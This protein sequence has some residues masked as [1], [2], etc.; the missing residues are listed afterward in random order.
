[1]RHV[2]LALMMIAAVGCGSISGGGADGGSPGNTPNKCHGSPP[3]APL[4]DA[5]GGAACSA[6]AP[7]AAPEVCIMLPGTDAGSCGPACQS[8]CDCPAWLSCQNGVCGTCSDSSCGAGERCSLVTLPHGA[9][10]SSNNDCGLGGYC[11]D[12]YCDELRVCTQC[13]GGCQTCNSNAQCSPGEVCDNGACATCSSDS[14][15]GPS[16]KCAATHTSVQC[17]CSQTS[18]C[19]SGETCQSGICAPLPVMGCNDPD[20]MNRCQTGQACING[21]CGACSSFEDCN[22]NPD[23]LLGSLQGLACI[24]GACAACTANSQ[25]GGGQAC[26]G[27]TCGTCVVDAQCGASGKCSDGYCVCSTD[28]QCDSGQRCGAGVCVE[29]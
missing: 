5:D 1:M 23:G 3:L 8:D 16:A 19:A 24:N 6:T 7:C 12:G 15:C 2:H 17:T 26:V 21:S 18:D 13:T 14:Q 28:A 4:V 25:C 9:Q 22:T 29:M 10:C 20:P 11:Q 27:G